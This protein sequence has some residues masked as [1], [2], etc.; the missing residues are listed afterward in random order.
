MFLYLLYYFR[1]I[2][3]KHKTNLVN[4]N[5]VFIELIQPKL[6]M[7]VFKKV[8]GEKFIC[9]FFGANCLMPGA[10]GKLPH[11]DYPYLNMR[12]PGEKVPFKT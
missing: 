11:I 12:K 7:E 4:L 2:I 8:L 5:K 3:F 10:R 6:A 9:G 1:G